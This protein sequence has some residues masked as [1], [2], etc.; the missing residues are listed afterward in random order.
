MTVAVCH[1]VCQNCLGMMLCF[2][3][4]LEL[5]SLTIPSDCQLFDTILAVRSLI[6]VEFVFA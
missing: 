3:I 2:S 4:K 1:V 5:V 6:S